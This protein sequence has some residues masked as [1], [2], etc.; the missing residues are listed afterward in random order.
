MNMRNDE[1]IKDTAID[2]AEV[3]IDT[4]ARHFMTGEVQEIFVD[5]PIIKN[6]SA[7]VALVHNVRNYSIAKKLSAFVKAVRKGN[8]DKEKYQQLA[9]KYGKEKVLEE[10]IVQIDR[11]GKEEQAEVC[12]H[13][14]SALLD[15]QLNWEEYCRLA[16][17][18]E[19]SNPV[20]LATF[21]ESLRGVE[22]PSEARSSHELCALSVAL[23]PFGFSGDDHTY[24]L[25]W[26]F[27][28]LGLRPF[29]DNRF[30]N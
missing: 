16:Y 10:I 3:V 13:L 29:Q 28:R 6:I 23:G 8:V 22:N 9:D 14:F 30:K 17:F 5:L 7:I 12:G 26:K 24:E 1:K 27:W 15:G 11:F 21:F 20:S 19:R 4:F 25:A 18:V 2:N